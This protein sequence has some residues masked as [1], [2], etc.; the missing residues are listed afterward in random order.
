MFRIQPQF[1]RTLAG[2][3]HAFTE[4]E[5][6]PWPTLK[7]FDQLQRYVVCYLLIHNYYAWLDGV[8]P[9]PTL[10]RLLAIVPMGKRQ[11]ITFISALR[12]G[13]LVIA[14]PDPRDARARHLRPAPAVIAEIG[15]SPRLFVAAAGQLSRQPRALDQVLAQDPGLLGRVLALSAAEVLID[16]TLIHPFPTVL[17]FASRDCGYMLL[18]MV[19]RA[20]YAR[21][22]GD[23]RLDLTL[24][25]PALAQKLQ[26]SRGHIANLFNEA[27]AAGLF[28]VHDGALDR[29][30]DELV[31]EFERWAALQMAHYSIVLQRLL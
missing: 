4:V 16:G 12:A 18:T 5:G 6:L 11:T 22:L 9:A 8:G 27:E 30:S 15:R 24:S 29:L 21:A 7:T 2:Y 14:E 19:M 13:G 10:A 17:R 25:H 26:V 3:C 31:D 23:T 28:R 1:V 20:H